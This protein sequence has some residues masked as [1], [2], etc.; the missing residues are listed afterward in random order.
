MMYFFDFDRIGQEKA[1]GRYTIHVNVAF[2]VTQAIQKRQIELEWMN[3]LLV[4]SNH[5]QFKLRVHV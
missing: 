5:P 4:D 3:M 2:Q 1:A